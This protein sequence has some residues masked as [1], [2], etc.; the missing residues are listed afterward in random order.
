MYLVFTHMPAESYRRRLRSLLLC[1]CDIFRA[2]INSLVCWFTITW[3]GW[4]QRQRQSWFHKHLDQCPVQ[5]EADAALHLAQRQR[6]PAADCGHLSDHTG[7]WPCPQRLCSPLQ[8]VHWWV[9][10]AGASWLCVLSVLFSLYSKYIGESA[11]LEPIGF[12]CPQHLCSPLQQVHWWVCR[13]GARWLCVSSTSLFPSTASTLVSL[14]CWGQL[15]LCVLIVLFPLYSKYIGESAVLGPGGF[16]CPQCPCS[17]LQRVHWWVC[18]AGASWLCVLSVLVPLYSEYTGESAVLEPVGFVC[19]Q[20]LCSPLQR[21]RWWVCH[22]GASC[23]HVFL[24]LEAEGRLRSLVWQGIFLPQSASSAHSL[25]VSV[26][27]PCAITCINIC[28]HVNVP[29]NWQP[30]HCLDTGKLLH[31]L[32]GMGSAAL[33]YCTHW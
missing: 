11:V 1:L 27:P 7:C 22:A 21:V 23:L 18:C 5:S 25:M 19:P 26:W 15:A 13:A 6:G 33:E 24:H 29:P 4:Q 16:V 17:P 10:R 32:I 2:L 9:C 3:S 12:V 14:L 31:T 28:A 20:R 8:Q 30:Y